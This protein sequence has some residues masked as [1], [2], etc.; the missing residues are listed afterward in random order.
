MREVYHES[1]KEKKDRMVSLTSNKIYYKAKTLTRD[2]DINYV[3]IKGPFYQ[4]NKT[5][6]NIYAHNNRAHKYM[7]QKFIFI[8][9][10]L[11]GKINNLI[12]NSWRLKKLDFSNG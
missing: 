3:I 7:K 4:E 11:K 5:I 9:K 8:K 2:K 12:I 6:V 1:G 10:E